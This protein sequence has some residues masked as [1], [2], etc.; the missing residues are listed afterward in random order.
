MGSFSVF[1]MY[2][3]HKG[4]RAKPWDNRELDIFEGIKFFSF[5]LTT[6][7][8]TAFTLLYTW[9]NNLFTIFSML[10]M[11]PVNS[12]ITANIALEVFVFVSAFFTTY[13]AM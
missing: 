9:L 12:F 1:K 5:V 10:A 4:T 7:S 13:R 8:Q 2:D 11:L 6:I 3:F